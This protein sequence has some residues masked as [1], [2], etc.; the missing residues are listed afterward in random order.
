MSDKAI[1]NTVFKL[2]AAAVFMVAFIPLVMVPL[3]DA[4]CRVL[5]INGRTTGEQYQ[6]V[7]V[8]VDESRTVRIQF[9]TQNAQD[10]PWRFS[11]DT[12]SV[13]VHPGAVT[14]TMFY[15]KNITGKD[16]VSQAIP[17]IVPSRAARF[18]HKTECFCFNHQPLESGGEALMPMRFIVDQDLP[19]DIKT[20]TLTYTIFDV[21]EM[22]ARD[23][24]RDGVVA[25]R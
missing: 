20:I 2:V 19:Q 11:T 16:M 17:S 14:E 24:G 21:T 6:A 5:G 15:A 4:M 18:F 3:Y 12:T 13:T 22:A 8:R 7:D 25:A 10:M 9:V 1:R 23:S